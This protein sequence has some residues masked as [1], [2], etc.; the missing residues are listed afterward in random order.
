MLGVHPTWIDLAYLLRNIA[1]GMGPSRIRV[2]ASHVHDGIYVE[3]FSQHVHADRS[4]DRMHEI[5]GC[6][7]ASENFRDLAQLQREEMSLTN[8]SKVVR[9]AIYHIVIN[10]N[11]VPHQC[12]IYTIPNSD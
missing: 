11:V 7:V 4:S 6:S 3:V 12:I 8:T 10:R 2:E 9:V 1:G 5:L